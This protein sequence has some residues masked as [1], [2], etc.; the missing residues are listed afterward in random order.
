MEASPRLASFIHFAPSPPDRTWAQNKMART[1]PRCA[2]P[3]K[4]NKR[5]Q[6]QNPVD[7]L[8]ES[9]VLKLCRAKDWAGVIQRCRSNPEETKPVL[10]PENQSGNRFYSHSAKRSVANTFFNSSEVDPV[11]FETPLGLACASADLDSDMLHEVIIALIMAFPDQVR[12]SQLIPGHTPLR[13]V[14]L[15]PRCDVRTLR[16]L[17]DADEICS[18]RESSAISA[19]VRADRNGQLPVDHLLMGIQLGATGKSLELFQAY[20]EHKAQKRQNDQIECSPLIRL[21]TIGSSLSM[22]KINAPGSSAGGADQEGIE[23]ARRKRILMTAKFLLDS[24][25]SILLQCSKLTGCSPLH[26]AL[27]NFGNYLPLINVLVSR[28]ESQQL[29]GLRNRF[30]D[31]PLHVA[32]SVGAPFEVLKT[33]VENTIAAAK[34]SNIGSPL[35]IHPL[36]WSTNDSGYTPIDLEWVRHIE[37]GQG[38]YST[39]SFYPLE[40]SGVT[41]HC[42]KQ[43]EYYHDLLR[44]A[45]DNVIKPQTTS[46]VESDQERLAGAKNTFGSL[47]DRISLLVTAAA[48]SIPATSSPTLLHNVCKLSALQGPRLP[49]PLIELFLWIHRDEVLLK[50]PFGMLPIHYSLGFHSSDCKVEG[51]APSLSHVLKLLRMEPTSSQVPTK[52]GRL[53]LHLILDHAT[54]KEN[55]HPCPEMVQLLEALVRC[56]PESIDRPDPLTRLDPFLLAARNP[57]L[58]LDVAYFLLRRSPSRC[59]PRVPTN[60]A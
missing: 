37:G 6:E 12:A 46:N 18:M 39:R 31:L 28:S 54:H 53:P 48:S 58:P 35:S 47:L 9:Q 44:E 27:R 19:L 5:R 4:P 33:I 13:D 50:D 29:M 57:F 2:G 26:A 32:C 30:G 8:V 52:D 15:N 10:V 7:V 42:F 24:D 21:L 20:F 17:L 40:P 41:K 1:P 36:L 49:E 23:C 11:Y 34:P 56:F 59:A 22:K 14:I 38:F 45:V 55:D 25:P 60:G 51:K 3:G 43:D 16:A